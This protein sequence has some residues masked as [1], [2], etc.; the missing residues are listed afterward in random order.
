VTCLNIPRTCKPI[1]K[2]GEPLDLGELMDVLYAVSGLVGSELSVSRA[3]RTFRMLG[4][5]FEQYIWDTAS[6][7]LA[8]AGR[9]VRA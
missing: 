8:E 5:T 7:R 2:D 9:P 4:I 6:G 1:R 3:T